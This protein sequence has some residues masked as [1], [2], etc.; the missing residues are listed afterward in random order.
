MRPS[1]DFAIT[2]RDL[3]AKLKLSQEEIAQRLNVS[4]ATVN[5]WENG[6]SQPQGAA[7]DAI[8]KLLEEVG[9]EPLVL[10]ADDEVAGDNQPRRRKRGVAKSAVLSTKSMEQMLWDCACDIRGEKDAPKFKDY[11][12]PLVFIK[13]LSDVFDDEVKR[14]V[15]TYGDLETAK[16][17][18]EADHSLVRF[19][20]P[21]EC[22]WPVVSRRESFKWPRDKTP[23]TLGEQLTMTVRAIAKANANKLAGVIDI[24]DYNAAPHGE[25][26]ISDQALSGVIETLSDPRYRLGLR[27]VEPD[28]LGRAYEYLLRKFAESQGQSAGEFFTPQE[29]GWLMAYI[30]RPRQGEE[31]CDFAC[32]SAGL[33]IKCEL[34]L[35]QRELKVS[36]PLK[37]YGQ[38]LT[39]SSYAIARM[40]MVI[41]DM[42]GEI[43][44][45]NSM[46]NPKFRD[47]DTSLKRFDIVVA[48]PMWN[49][50]FDESTFEKDPFDRFE[51]QGGTT[52]GK[53]DWAWLQHT[54]ALLKDNGRAA[55]VLDTQ[56]V[57]RGS[58][59]RSEDKE[60][61]IRKWF[62]QKDVIEGVI[63]LPEN[64]FYNTPADG[65]IIVLRKNKAKARVG[66]IVLVNASQEFKKGQPKNF[67]PLESLRKIA[68]A[69]IAG[70]DVE[71][72]VKVITTDDA[73]SR[74]FNLSPSLY[75]SS[76]SQKVI[77]AIPEILN[78][79]NKLACETEAL[80]RDI[81]LIRRTLAKWG[82]SPKRTAPQQQTPIGPIPH[83]WELATIGEKCHKPQYGL[84]A[85][86]NSKPVGPKFL[87]ITDITDKGV[88]W[89]TVPYCECENEILDFYRL[90]DNDILFARIGATTGKSFIVRNP[91][92]AVFAS[93]LIRVRPKEGM[94]PDFLYYFFQ[95]A[96]YWRQVD[97]NKGNNLKG[98]VNG[99][100]L[101]SMIIP[102][103]PLEEQKQIAFALQR[104]EQN[105]RTAEAQGT[106]LSHLLDA[107]TY[108]AM[109]GE[110]P[111]NTFT[112][113]ITSAKT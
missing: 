108:N 61:N 58:G 100:I 63:L 49:Q 60:K 87:R 41:H 53:G 76:P 3:R 51:S 13:R 43:V 7:R 111:A 22:R 5:R 64:L 46:T 44:R 1:D 98:G 16:A 88:N 55:V 19:Y 6:K 30:V 109:T 42:E 4:F 110:L 78:D 27:D 28:F 96:A 102:V 104:I 91:P 47:S 45:G 2:V 62:V 59:R 85:S 105:L 67:I 97:A 35:I 94:W 36:R 107:L 18:L 79:L 50:P 20:L 24:V 38:E 75:V 69:F 101:A 54:L 56:A 106:L 68:D 89:N 81:D 40:N 32:G 52:S 21:P 17:V 26:E 74:D 9:D 57:S 103:P 34:A 12:L 15:E 31:A 113:K 48:N 39:G 70:E 112:A 99:S 90:H 66:K 83:H 86:A 71:N 72:I 93:Y 25:R 14:L 80:T 33:L 73:A 11:I 8:N 77:R 29:V 95:S 84:T 65:V 37:L 23:K 82:S 10:R 92:P